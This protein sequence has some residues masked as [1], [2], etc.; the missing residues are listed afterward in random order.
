MSIAVRRG[1]GTLLD[2]STSANG[3]LALIVFFFLTVKLYQI[4][5]IRK[6]DLGRS[7]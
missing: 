6:F 1:E 4:A 7:F 5:T 3:V 2:K